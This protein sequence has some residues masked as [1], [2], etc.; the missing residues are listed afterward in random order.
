MRICQYIAPLPLLTEKGMRH[1][2]RFERLQT[3]SALAS[4]ICGHSR[5]HVDQL[6]DWS[7]S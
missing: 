7:E 1:Q 3:V 6:T 2:V 5:T 4:D